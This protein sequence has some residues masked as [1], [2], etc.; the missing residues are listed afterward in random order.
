MISVPKR[1]LACVK[2]AASV[3]LPLIAWLIVVEIWN[4]QNFLSSLYLL[5]CRKS[6]FVFK[7]N[8]VWKFQKS[9]ILPA[10]FH[11]PDSHLW[12]LCCCQNP[13]RLKQFFWESQNHL[14]KVESRLIYWYKRPPRRHHFGQRLTWGL[15]AHCNHINILYTYLTI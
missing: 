1:S 13:I 7:P 6:H 11:L 14:K 8:L 2:T 10:I 4:K 15:V 5:Y 3:V 12:S 9:R